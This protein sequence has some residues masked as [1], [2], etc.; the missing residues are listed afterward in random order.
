MNI[1]TFSRRDTSV[2][3][4]WWWTIDRWN[5]SAVF[6]LMLM[7]VMLSFSASPAVADRLNLGSFYFVKRHILMIPFA[8]LAM[9]ILSLGSPKDIRKFSLLGF[10][11]CTVALIATLL[12]GV[13]V[14]GA[15]RWINLGGMSLQASEFMKP[16]FAVMTAWVLSHAHKNHRF[17][18]LTLSF[19]LLCGVLGLLLL[20]PDLGMSVVMTSTWI[21][22]LFIA[23]MPI[24]WMVV[25]GVTAL[26]G[27]VGAYILLPH[28]AKR[29]DQFLDPASSPDVKNELYQIH[30]SL[31]AFANGGV[32]G[33]GP[34]EGIVKRFVPDAHADFVFAVAGE[35]FGLFLCLLIVGIFAFIVIR[36]LIKSISHGNLFALLAVVGLISQFGLQAVINMASSLHLIPTKGMT[37]PFISYGGSSLVALGIA[38]GMVFALTRK[39]HGSVVDE[40]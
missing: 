21:A 18:G 34:G 10:A 29:I 35:E 37:M 27:I 12:V 26:F 25:L 36:S 7:G 20:Q 3:G 28:V 8:L 23:G 11:L 22:Q 1:P 38:L 2:L 31:D 15:R 14:K 39:Q 5:L 33:K 9:L 13:E 4:K 40:V 6:L 24:I 19:G 17:P 30:Q 16:F 32:L